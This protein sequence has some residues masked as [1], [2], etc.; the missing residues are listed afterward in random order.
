MEPV[1][2]TQLLVLFLQLSVGLVDK[3]FLLFGLL[4]AG[5]EGVDLPLALFEFGLEVL[6]LGVPPDHVLEQVHCHQ[7]IIK[8]ANFITRHGIIVSIKA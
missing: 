1:E 2:R 3:L 8:S 4:E 5:L 7:T 6:P